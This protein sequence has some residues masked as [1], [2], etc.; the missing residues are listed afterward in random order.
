MSWTGWMRRIANV[1]LGG[2]S[3]SRGKGLPLDQ[4]TDDQFRVQNEYLQTKFRSLPSSQQRSFA[5]IISALEQVQESFKNFAQNTRDRDEAQT[6][7]NKY[8]AKANPDVAKY[9]Q[10]R[11]KLVV[12]DETFDH[13]KDQIRKSLKALG[14][15][16]IVF[17]SFDYNLAVDVAQKLTP[18][19]H[20][21][22]DAAGIDRD[23]SSYFEVF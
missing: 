22:T 5:I 1:F 15:Q 13:Q 9:S 19:V 8:N 10:E 20:G 21:I 3:A 23:E 16:I 2:H 12:E 17:Q 4:I 6:E 7:F 11:A 18:L 14:K